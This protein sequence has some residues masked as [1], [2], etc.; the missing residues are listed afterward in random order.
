M[1][2][3]SVNGLGRCSYVAVCFYPVCTPRTTCD[4]RCMSAA[5]L[6]DLAAASSA[7]CRDDDDSARI[8]INTLDVFSFP[9]AGHYD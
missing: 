2:G 8:S 4:H 7:A 3:V 6:P 5:C 1:A 9:F